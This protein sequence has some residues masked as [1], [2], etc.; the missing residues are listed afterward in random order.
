MCVN[1]GGDAALH[2]LAKGQIV[3]VIGEKNEQECDSIADEHI[4]HPAG[5]EVHAPQ[6][7]RRQ[8]DVESSRPTFAQSSRLV[9]SMSEASIANSSREPN[10]SAS[11][12]DS[13]IT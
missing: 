7:R 8:Q 3:D 12:S 13:N 10:S 2:P 1:F 4:P 11:S 6:A 5:V 9:T